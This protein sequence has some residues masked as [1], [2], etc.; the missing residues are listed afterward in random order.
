MT[1]TKNCEPNAPFALTLA[2]RTRS[3]T[4]PKNETA[5]TKSA[6]TATAAAAPVNTTWNKNIKLMK[7]FRQSELN[8]RANTC[9]KSNAPKYM[10]IIR[11]VHVRCVC[12]CANSRADNDREWETVF[13]THNIFVVVICCYCCFFLLSFEG[14]LLPSCIQCIICLLLFFFFSIGIVFI[15]S[16]VPFFTVW[17]D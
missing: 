9:N 11:P 6:A 16:W 12:V 13:S 14:V 15:L 10:Y 8:D 17:C 5:N 7:I 2:H 3:N 1:T 4:W